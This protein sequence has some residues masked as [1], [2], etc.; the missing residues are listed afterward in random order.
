M[1]GVELL[2]ADGALA[3]RHRRDT[4]EAE[5]EQQLQEGDGAKEEQKGGAANREQ[6]LERILLALV[7]VDGRERRVGPVEDPVCTAARCHA[8]R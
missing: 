4:A 1:N 3:V 7:A 2:P 5:E 6:P 8:G